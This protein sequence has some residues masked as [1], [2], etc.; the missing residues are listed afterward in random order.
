MFDENQ[1]AEI[2]GLCYEEM[3]LRHQLN[4]QMGSYRY[5]CRFQGQP[6]YSHTP[7]GEIMRDRE[8]EPDL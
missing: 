3:K 8:Q 7:I 6:I 4:Q 5:Q 1:Q 2:R